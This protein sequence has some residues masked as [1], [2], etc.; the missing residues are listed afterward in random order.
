MTLTALIVAHNEEAQLAACL[1]SVAFAD[2]IVVVLDRCTDRSKDVALQHGAKLVEG[3]W[4]NEGSRRKAGID[5]SLGPWILEL[6]ADE[7]VTQELA[8][9]IGRTLPAAQPGIYGIPFNNFVGGRL[10]RHGWGAYNGVGA[11]SCLFYKGLKLWGED[12]VHPK[13][14]MTG[15]RTRLTH[16]IDH[17]VDDDL[18]DMFARL[19]RYTSLAAKQAFLEG[20]IPGTWST[21]RRVFGR[22]YKSYLRRKGYKEGVYGVALALFSALY[23]LM[24]CIK[25]RALAASTHDQ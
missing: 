19:N 2:E 5:A 6:D 8:A 24:T 4:P 18:D 17:Y 20:K 22:F 25:A 12:L 1:Q 23:P 15:P 13:V 16:G 21:T 3:A 7:R 14:T 11:K 10:I 9:E